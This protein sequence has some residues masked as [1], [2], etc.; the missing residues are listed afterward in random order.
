[1]KKQKENI[2]RN[3]VREIEKQTIYGKE[4][5]EVKKRVNEKVQKSVQESEKQNREKMGR[6]LKEKCKV[7]SISTLK[8]YKIKDEK[9]TFKNGGNK[10]GILKHRP[11]L[12]HTMGVVKNKMLAEKI[13]RGQTGYLH[14][15][16][17]LPSTM[18]IFD[19]TKDIEK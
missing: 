8:N 11:A 13:D 16:T 7:V 6:I 17:A 3:R 2:V 10:T 12:Q 4:E 19:G 18:R 9:F 5:I 1:M 14:E 15:L